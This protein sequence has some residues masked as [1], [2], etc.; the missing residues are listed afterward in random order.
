M[1]ESRYKNQPELDNM[2]EI[3]QNARIRPPVQPQRVEIVMPVMPQAIKT[4]AGLVCELLALVVRVL[5]LACELVALVA[6]IVD[7]ALS[8]VGGI[9]DRVRRYLLGIAHGL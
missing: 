6:R 4:A 8:W 3:P 5:E 1:A 9:C 2:G 7:T